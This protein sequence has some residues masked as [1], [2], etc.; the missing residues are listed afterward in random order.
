MNKK[1]VYCLPSLYIPG[2][3]ERVLT[4]KANYLADKTDYDI[5]IILTD[6]KNKVPYYKLSPKVKIIHLDIEF[7]VLW[8]K[9]FLQK[10]ALYLQKQRIYKRKLTEA[11]YQ[12][13]PDI[14]ISMLRREIN[15]LS[16]I[17]DGSIKIGELHV[18][19]NNYRNFEGKDAYLIKKLFSKWWMTQLVRKLKRLDKF[20]VLT[21]EDKENWKE[22]KNTCVISNPLPFQAK[23][24]SDCSAKQVI[25]V[26]RYT[27]QKGFDL[28]IEAWITVNR[29]HPDWSLQIYGDGDKDK[30]Q[31][32]ANERGIG[33]TF[34]CNGSV[35]NIAEKYKE[36]SFFVLSSRFEGFGMV[37]AEAMACG[38]PAVS[39]A[40]PCGP[41]DI[42]CDKQ[43]GLLVENGNIAE[44][45]DKI[46][47]LIEHEDERKRMGK[48][49]YA[50]VWRFSEEN[51]MKQWIQLFD[52]L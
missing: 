14:T 16:S 7:N 3:M 35:Q 48:C 42:I 23:E 4:I 30:Y 1:I 9:P 8:N 2:G 52:N 47:Y 51:I 25:A 11:L 38:I 32:M 27:W 39:F 10:A 50:N 29:K 12:I 37:I 19:R 22:L 43:D 40:C 24:I 46:C 13:R 49:A 18:N 15:F 44:L 21:H 31:Q 26:G 28:L 45:A 20:V 34:N 5:Y 41:N 33:K 17:H 6:G 36:S